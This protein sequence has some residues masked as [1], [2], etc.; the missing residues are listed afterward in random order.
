MLPLLTLLA[1]HGVWAWGGVHD[2]TLYLESIEPHVTLYV[3]GR[4]H[5][6][7]LFVGAPLGTEWHEHHVAIFGRW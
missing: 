5:R 2:R 3:D 1:M 4:A 7:S 6:W